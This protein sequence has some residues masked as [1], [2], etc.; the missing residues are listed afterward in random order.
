MRHRGLARVGATAGPE[1]RFADICPHSREWRGRAV[2][3]VHKLV[4]VHRSLIEDPTG[5]LAPDSEDMDE[6]GNAGALT[7]SAAAARGIT[8]SKLGS[9]YTRV[10]HGVHVHNS[11]EPTLEVRCAAAVLVLP[12]DATFSDLTAVE[13][14][15]LPLPFGVRRI[16]PLDVTVCPPIDRPVGRGV[17]GYRRQLHPTEVTVIGGLRVTTAARTFVDL[18]AEFDEPNL[19][20]VGDAILRKGLA[21]LAGLEAAVREAAG[22]RGVARARRAVVRLDGRSLSAPESLLRVRIEDAGLPRPSLNVNVYDS[23]GGWIACPDLLYEEAMI[24]IE[25]EGER[26]LSERQFRLD[27]ARDQLMT[28]AGF[29]VVR[30]GP[31]DLPANATMLPDTLRRL[32]EERAPWM[33]AN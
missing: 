12:G 9:N 27:L 2:A 16:R 7:N 11:V 18:A 5:R 14:S 22:R 24:A 13:L 28:L 31:R 23:C 17:R 33:L 1:R 10:L 19:I 25:Y 30:A 32:L 15:G 20:V 29:V 26:H 4:G 21:S 3:P 6:V 8:R